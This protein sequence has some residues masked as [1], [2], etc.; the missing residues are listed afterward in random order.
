MIP[1]TGHVNIDRQLINKIPTT[2]RSE[3]PSPMTYW[4]PLRQAFRCRHASQ[5][6]VQNGVHAPTQWSATATMDYSRWIMS[7]RGRTKENS[8]YVAVKP[9]CGLT[10]LRRYNLTYEGFSTFCSVRLNAMH[11]SWTSLVSLT[12][13]LPSK[14]WQL[15]ERIANDIPGEWKAEKTDLVSHQKVRHYSLALPMQV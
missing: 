10:V 13:L 5:F 7:S 11:H 2:G 4:R 14:G 12:G 9:V 3:C 15:T 8:S 1:R 6:C